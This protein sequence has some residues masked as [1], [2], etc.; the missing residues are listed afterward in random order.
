MGKFSTGMVFGA[1]LGIGALMLDK[2]SMKKAKKMIHQM[3]M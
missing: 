2:K 3:H 1:M